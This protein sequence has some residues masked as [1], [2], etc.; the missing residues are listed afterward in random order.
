MRIKLARKALLAVA[1]IGAAGTAAGHGLMEDPPS[2]NWICGAISKPDEVLNGVAETP[3]CGEA[4]ADD[5]NGGY[6][7]MSVLTHD[8]GRTAVTP[9]PQH[10]CGFGSETFNGGATPWDSAIDWPTSKM[11]A[12]RQ[13]FKWNIQWGPH[14]DD[15]EE[16]RYWITKP[17]FQF[18]ADQPLTWNDFESTEFCT[19]QYNDANPN[20]NPDVIP[21]KAST[22]FRTFCDVPARQG[23]HVIYGEWGRNQFTFE[24]FHGCVDVTFDGT[25]PPPDDSVEAVIGLNPDVDA[26]I[27]EDTI[28]LDGS[29][30]QGDDLTY[31]WSVS[32]PDASLYT[33]ADADQAVTTLQLAAPTVA[34]SL[35]VSLTV[36]NDGDSSSVSRT[37]LHEPQ[38]VSTWIDLGPLT[39]A[40]QALAAGDQVSVRTV[41]DEGQDVFYPATPFTLDAGNASAAAWPLAL[42]Q[43]VNA[44]AG[45][46]IAVGV[47][48]GDDEVTPVA[49]ATANRVY[50]VNGSGL[51]S[52]F[53][54]IE[55]ASDPGPGPG[56]DCSF[57]V[58][59]GANPWW[60]GADVATDAETIVLDFTG[61]GLDLA[62]NV[63]I[64][65]GVFT[66]SVSGQLVTLTKPAWVNID[67]PG[68]I[69]FNASNNP[70]LTS[71]TAPG[72][73][74]K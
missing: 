59:G 47:L 17:G 58:R 8:R 13:E 66:T 20:G 5:F 15:T 63:K 27:G 22:Q 56:G 18:R 16:F 60:A 43:A 2:R 50:A 19:L 48:G 33:I 9:L 14:F 65:S 23:R 46:D 53:A 11:S 30:S 24:R 28:A 74:A 6:Q 35:T 25:A 54:I 32:A 38:V 44:I 62:S 12:G 70:A 69:G 57:T 31:S 40:S 51:V 71:F 67:N 37:I 45:A 26:V 64:D 73:K 1:L 4:F 29:A 49:D 10:V 42:A 52:A 7:F 34:Q 41:S 39:S 3:I 36:S 55:R 68:Y 61:T 72:C 21:L